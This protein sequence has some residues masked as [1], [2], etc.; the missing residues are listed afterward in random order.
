MEFYTN[1]TSDW[2]NI[3]ITGYLDGKKYREKIPYKPYLFVPGDGEY[4][5]V[6]GQRVSRFDFDSIK[7]A[8]EFVRQ[9]AEIS[10]FDLYGLTDFPYVYINDKYRQVE[11]DPSLIKVGNVDIETD[12]QNGYGDIQKADREIISITLKVF[13]EKIF[14]VFGLKPYQTEYQE[15]LDLIAQGFEI[16][17]IQCNSEKQLLKRFLTLWREADLDVI[18]GYNSKLFDIPYIVKRLKINFGEETANQLSPY[19][20]L[21]QRTMRLYNRDNDVFDIVGMAHLDWMEVYKKF[22]TPVNGAEESYSLNHL[23]SKILGAA[24][25][26]YHKEYGTLANLYNRNHNIFIDYNIIDVW[27]VEQMDQIRGYIN[28]VFVIAYLTKTNFE[29]TMGTV[30][31]WDIMIHNYLMDRKI[32]VPTVSKNFKERNIAGGYVKEVHP[33]YIKNVIGLDFTSLYPKLTITYNISPETMAGTLDEIYGDM[34]VDHILNGKLDKYR[35]YLVENNLAVT[36]KGTLFKRDK[37]GFFPAL[38][39][40]LFARRQQYTKAE[41]EYDRVLAQVETE[42][43]KR[44]IEKFDD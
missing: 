9:Y 14:W 21:K 18:V 44:G 32:V 22:S 42:L 26:D 29:D 5:T 10:N 16:R 38:M 33:S 12:S 37:Q 35:D 39:D 7:E 8:R 19:G 24:K 3:L 2:D 6:N 41:E 43:K 36:G 34:S 11:Y 31:V 13:G 20:K 23:S 40:S 27:R 28:L 4:R 1:F 15:L 30:K 17:Y 25:L